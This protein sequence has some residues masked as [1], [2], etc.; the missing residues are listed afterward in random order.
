MQRCRIFKHSKAYISAIAHW[1]VLKFFPWLLS[2]WKGSK[3]WPC[4]TAIFQE[5]LQNL[6]IS[7]LKFACWLTMWNGISETEKALY[8]FVYP[9]HLEASLFIV[10]AHA[11]SLLSQ[12]KLGLELREA[13]KKTVKFRKLVKKRWGGCQNA[14]WKICKIFQQVKI[15]ASF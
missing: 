5:A 14:N 12:I 15:L 4:S 11:K 6:K 3:Y 8:Y 9:K 7:E 10:K 13:F 2:R 1:I